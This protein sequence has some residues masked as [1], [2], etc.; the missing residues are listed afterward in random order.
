[1]DDKDIFRSLHQQH[2]KSSLPGLD[3]CP[4][5]RAD[6]IKSIMRRLNAGDDRIE[7]LQEAMN[8]N[9]RVTKENAET[10]KDV[11]EI[12]VM[13]RSLF[14]MAGWIGNAIKWVAGTVL[15]VGGAYAVIEKWWLK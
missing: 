12:V 2:D 9:T 5:C 7:A 8:E 10:L 13:G 11:K 4:E 15:A 14:R 1:M 6:A 3:T